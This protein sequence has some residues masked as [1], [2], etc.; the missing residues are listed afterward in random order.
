MG[1][2]TRTPAA[3]CGRNMSYTSVVRFVELIQLGSYKG[4]ELG[5]SEGW[6]TC[7]YIP[8]GNGE[9][10]GWFDFVSHWKR[11]MR[12]GSPVLI[13]LKAQITTCGPEIKSESLDGAVK[14]VSDIVTKPSSTPTWSHSTPSI[15]RSFSSP[16]SPSNATSLQVDIWVTESIQRK[17]KE[18]RCLEIRTWAVDTTKKWRSS[19][20]N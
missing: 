8:Q 19:L 9:L 2:T 13:G 16:V 14:R 5:S 7:N 15:S 20:I 18:A 1:L 10:N 6:C 3:R 12:K 11:I 17:H 4:C